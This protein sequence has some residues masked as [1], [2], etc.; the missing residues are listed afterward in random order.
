M[1]KQKDEKTIFYE[2]IK[3]KNL[4][5]SEQRENVLDVFLG[6]EKHLTTEELYQIVKKSYPKISF[7]TVYRTMKLLTGCGLCRELKFK[8]WLTRHE[9][10]YGHEHHDHLVCT[11]CGKYIEIFDS[12]IEF[13]QNKIFK[14]NGF[15]PK[16]HK[17]ELYGICPSCQKK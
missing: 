6:I 1:K 16:C 14:E 8:D 5:H 9:H 17:M 3:D 12:K 4:K 10:V 11:K 13:L 2:Y 7:I 15:L